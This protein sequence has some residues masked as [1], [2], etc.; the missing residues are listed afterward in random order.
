[1]IYLDSCALVKL[2]VEE[3]ESSALRAWLDDKPDVPR[4]SSNLIRVELPRSIMRSQPG[5]ILQARAVVAK[6]RRIAMTTEI[7][8]VATMLQPA[9]L[10]SL[11]AIHLASAF[12]IHDRLTAFVSYDKRLIDAARAAGLPVVSPN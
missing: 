7:L 2:A 4:L 12:A 11:D 9:A 6:T 10:R 5:A 1:V 3:T 8:D